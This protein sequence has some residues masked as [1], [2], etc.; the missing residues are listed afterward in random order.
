[1]A[2]VFSFVNDR[3]LDFVDDIRVLVS[4]VYAV[5]WQGKWHWINS[6]GKN[7]N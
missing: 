5:Y 6:S 2:T 7:G 4:S 3:R 1:M